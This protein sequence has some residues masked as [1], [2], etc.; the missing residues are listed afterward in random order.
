MPKISKAGG[1][2]DDRIG[3]GTSDTTADDPTQPGRLRIDQENPTS[4]V[5]QEDEVDRPAPAVGAPQPETD[6]T[7]ADNEDDDDRERDEGDDPP[8]EQPPSGS[9]AEVLAWVGDDLDRARLALDAERN[10]PDPRKG[11]VSELERRLV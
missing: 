8:L 9:T 11:L 6:L 2:S 3:L 7:P 1:P 10:R 5:V 4:P